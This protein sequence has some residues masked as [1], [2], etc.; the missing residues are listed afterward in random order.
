MTVQAQDTVF[1][2][3]GNGVTTTFA[4]GCKILSSDDL[5]VFVDDERV[6]SGFTV[7]GVGSD[8][9][10]SITFTTAP[11]DGA[12]VRLERK[13]QL[14]RDT[15]YSQ[16]GDFRSDTVN[17]DF[18]RLWMA[19][20]QLDYL[21]GASYGKTSRVLK[22]GDD[23]T[24]GEGSYRAQ[25]NRI[26]DLADPVDQQDATTKN[27]VQ[28][29]LAG[30]LTDGAGQFVLDL[31]AASTGASLVGFIQQGA[32]AIP[33]T[34]NDRAIDVVSVT[35]YMTA[36]Q[37]ADVRARTYSVDVSTAC[38]AAEDALNALG[39]G[40]MYY[41]AGGYLL[42]TKQGV[43]GVLVRPRPNIEHV[44]CGRAT[45]FKA[46]DNLNSFFVFGHMDD[47][48]VTDVSDIGFRDFDIDLNGA[49]NLTVGPSPSNTDAGIYIS[50]ADNVRVNNVHMYN[51]A[52]RQCL[53]LGTNAT[54][55]TVKNVWISDCRFYHVATDITDNGAQDD[56]S[57]IYCYADNAIITR[58][59]LLNDNAGGVA[60]A[61]EHCSNGVISENI[62]KNYNTGVIT[63]VM[64]ADVVDVQIF[65]N[66]ITASQAW[67]LYTAN[68]RTAEG[69]RFFGNTCRQNY[70]KSP[71]YAFLDLS[72]NVTTPVTGA[73][74]VFDNTIVGYGD[75]TNDSSY[76]GLEFGDIAELHIKRNRFK[77]IIGRS[78][79]AGAVTRDTNAVYIEGNSFTN[80]NTTTNAS[81]KDII[82]F[83]VSTRTFPVV[84]LKGNTFRSDS[85]TYSNRPLT[86]NATVTDITLD[87]N[88][89]TG[90][91]FTMEFEWSAGKFTTSSVRHIS[92]TGI[93]PNFPAMN[94]STWSDTKNKYFYQKI[95]SNGD[96]YWNKTFGTTVIPTTGS[97]LANDRAMNITPT[98]G[99][100]KSWVCTVSGSPGTWVSE[101]NL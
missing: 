97:N 83:N 90:A 85:S 14:K 13:V 69:I 26:Q 29:Q 95:R 10:G 77:N 50:T 15:N 72:S 35:D 49:N 34:L 57:S 100:P 11:A 17:P 53:T 2:Y 51:N 66:T 73:V 25:N 18:D 54:P 62:I 9:G 37:K 67:H 92:G 79:N 87:G 41:P 16:N 75:S 21:A 12:A 93:T 5:Y 47:D 64:S 86:G 22:L 70:K 52:G 82:A 101:G 74:E 42:G 4:Y 40:M 65:G 88:T 36:A 7:N 28:T 71:G 78:I 84:T 80:C 30:F 1:P 31:L 44:G 55:R 32:G 76:F 45:V 3:T 63:S 98:V 96:T 23:D 58:N 24:N 20:Q 99:Q 38:Q 59:E 19:M 61:I 6:T 56:H 81:Y 39:G 27:W 48:T 46:A 33:R 94:G 68:S 89:V 91:G 8:S 60:T 43:H